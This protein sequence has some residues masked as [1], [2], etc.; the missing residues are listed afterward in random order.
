MRSSRLQGCKL[1]TLKRKKVLYNLLK[2]P[3]KNESAVLKNDKES[4][5]IPKE[6][7]TCQSGML[8]ICSNKNAPKS[9]ALQ[10]L[11]LMSQ[12]LLHTR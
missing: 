11:L 7:P 9:A 12:I 3:C 6:S 4:I 10:Q 5:Y 8:Q 1:K 2:L